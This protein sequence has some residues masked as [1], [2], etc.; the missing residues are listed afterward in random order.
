MNVWGYTEDEFDDEDE[1]YET[2]YSG[3]AV[4]DSEPVVTEADPPAT[5]DGGLSISDLI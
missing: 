2:S 3:V 1:G 4:S 5:A